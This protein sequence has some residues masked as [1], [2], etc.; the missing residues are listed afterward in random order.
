MKTIH[1]L[2]S[3]E[4]VLR[5]A[6]RQT[7]DRIPRI[8]QLEDKVNERLV[9]QFGNQELKRMLN[10]DIADVFFQP[11]QARHDFSAYFSRPGVSWDEWGRGRLWDDQNHYAEYLYPLEKAES[12]DE[13]LNYGWPAWDAPERW[14]QIRGQTD[15]YHFEGYAVSGAAE[16]TV[17]EIAWQL[18]SMDRLFADIMEEDEKAV[19]LLDKITEIRI[20]MARQYARIGVDI[21]ALGD[22]VA[23]Q[24]GLLM[25]P[26]MWRRWFRPRLERVIQAAR[27]EK[28]DILIQYHSDGQ[29]NQLVPDLI[30]AGVDI[31]N[32]VQP[33]C[34]DHAWIKKEFG[35][36][37][38]FSGGLG[39]QSVL[40]FGSPEEV[41]EHVRQTIE[42]LGSG[43]G[44]IVGPSH[45]IEWDV[46][47]E[48][49][50][51]MLD[52][53]DVFGVYQ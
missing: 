26:K 38:S 7:P 43:G 2:T 21:L 52:A 3:R 41:R 32:P 29:I 11:V 47:L 42:I 9:K 36:Q 22:D 14:D 37:L 46:S 25:S 50:Q 44:L 16:E 48:N 4:R 12:V 1:E 27:A 5:A 8:V 45:V 6:R 39:V 13:I 51:A 28:P 15:R 10:V 17:F 35:Q 19:L 24:N 40:P 30:A 34:V 18:R 31:L 20:E 33:E 23:M 53:I 49:I